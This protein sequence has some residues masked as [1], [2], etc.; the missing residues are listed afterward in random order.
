MS[1]ELVVLCEQCV[2]YLYNKPDVDEVNELRYQLFCANPS[3][4]SSLPPTKDAL[5]WHIQRAERSSSLMVAGPLGRSFSESR[6]PWVAS[7]CTKPGH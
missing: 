1:D 6:W 2:A 7:S 3:K 5:Y 4:S